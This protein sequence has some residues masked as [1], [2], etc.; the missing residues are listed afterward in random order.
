MKYLFI[1]GLFYFIIS[2][3]ST[4]IFII[5]PKSTVKSSSGSITSSKSYIEGLSKPSSRISSVFRIAKS[6]ESPILELQCFR[7][8][9]LTTTWFS[10]SFFLDLFLSFYHFDFWALFFFSLFRIAP[11]LKPSSSDLSSSFESAWLSWSLLSLS[12]W[13][14]LFSESDFK[15]S[16]FSSSLFF[17]FFLFVVIFFLCFTIN[18]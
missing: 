15:Y 7:S 3:T 18:L 10:G 5:A 16:E 1:S 4:G 14:W 13:L 6:K 9:T 17:F 2:I 11:P 12:F 8:N